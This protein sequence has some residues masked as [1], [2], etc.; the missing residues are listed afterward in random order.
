MSN[1]STIRLKKSTRDKLKQAGIKGED[2]D[3]I[4][5][6]LLG[7]DIDTFVVG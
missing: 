1:Y 2:Y 6:R 7:K 5:L 4:V 3:T